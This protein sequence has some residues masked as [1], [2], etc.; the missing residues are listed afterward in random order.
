MGKNEG[1]VIG[2][3]LGEDGVQSGEC[4]LGAD[5]DAG[6]GAIGEDENSSDGVDV[7]IDLCRYTL[8]VEFVLLNT[9]SVG[10]A[11]GVEDTNLAK[12][13]SM[14]AT[15]DNARTYYY[16][17][18]AGKF[19]QAG[20]VCLSTTLPVGLVEDV[21]VVVIDVSARKDIGDELHE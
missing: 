3:G 21:E 19:I 8:P 10:Q 12:N 18:L 17:V 9:A 14:P 7:L 20:R 13:L 1:D 6:D 11:R 16:P 15:F 4:I 5:C 2:H